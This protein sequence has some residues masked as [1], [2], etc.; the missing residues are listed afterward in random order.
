MSDKAKKIYEALIGGATKGLT[1]DGLFRH[2][3]E[4]CP[5]ATSKKIVKAS[6]FALSDPDLK[7]GNILHVIYAL[8]IKH[9]L[10]PWVPEDAEQPE[11][12]V[13][14]TK[15]KKAGDKEDRPER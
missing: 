3:L 4:E 1:D 8:A 5:K 11:P 12:P 14:P 7:D 10:D 6:L 15:R 2:V 13:Q 9:R